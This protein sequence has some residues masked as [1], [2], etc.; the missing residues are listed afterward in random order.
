[1]QGG[2]GGEDALELRRVDPASLPGEVALVVA[3]Q[4]PAEPV[5][6]G[7][8]EDVTVRG[9]G[10]GGVPAGLHH[11]ADALVALGDRVE[12]V[13]R[14]VA[15]VLLLLPGDLVREA[16]EVAAIGAERAR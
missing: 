10:Q 4:H 13:G 3:G 1:M 7:D 14:V 11:V 15:A 6:A 5:Q 16:V 8:G 9:L 2:V 12:L